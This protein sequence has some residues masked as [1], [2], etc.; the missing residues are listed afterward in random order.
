MGRCILLEGRHPYLALTDSILKAM[1]A[2]SLLWNWPDMA[3]ALML[4]FLGLFRPAELLRLR[5]T[6][7]TQVLPR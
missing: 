5:F 2:V 6:Y 3:L 7:M 4:G 1:V